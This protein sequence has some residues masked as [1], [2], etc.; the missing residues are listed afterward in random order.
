MVDL[1]N[2]VKITKGLKLLLTLIANMNSAMKINF[3]YLGVELKIT[4]GAGVVGEPSVDL[5]QLHIVSV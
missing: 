2:G 1:V 3:S 4:L 5:H